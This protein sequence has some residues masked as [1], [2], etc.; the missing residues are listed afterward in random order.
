MLFSVYKAWTFKGCRDFYL[1]SLS[2]Y[3]KT[4][5]EDPSTSEGQKEYVKEM[6]DSLEPTIQ[7]L[8]D[9]QYGSINMD[10]HLKLYGDVY[11]KDG[12]TVNLHLQNGSY[13]EG[14]ADDYADFDAAGQLT[15]RQVDVSS[16]M[17]KSALGKL[18]GW[19]KSGRYGLCYIRRATSEMPA[20]SI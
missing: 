17:N 19:K 9:K 13:F 6:M 11:A 15:P 16:D 18:Y 12:G 14:Q 3:Y 20:P 7:F 4:Q 8:K 10:G 1:R 2:Q 5:Y